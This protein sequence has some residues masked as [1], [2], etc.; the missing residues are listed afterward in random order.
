L[1]LLLACEWALGSTTGEQEKE[2][3]R[4]RQKEKEVYYFDAVIF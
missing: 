1:E 3:G 4:G 2:K